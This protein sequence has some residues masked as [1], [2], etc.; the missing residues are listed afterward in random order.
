M[1][2]FFCCVL[3]ASPLPLSAVYSLG[4][5]LGVVAAVP[6]VDGKY[7]LTL[8]EKL[9]V[10]VWEV[11]SS[12]SI[13]TRQIT[14]LPR[15]ISF[16]PSRH[17]AIIADGSGFIEWDWT[18]KPATIM[19]V[20]SADANSKESIQNA[21]N[22]LFL[23]VSP[24]G[25]MLAIVDTLSNVKIQAIPSGKPKTVGSA[26]YAGSRIQRVN[27]VPGGTLLCAVDI[28]KI[29]IID[30]K[31]EK[32]I[33]SL[34]GHKEAISSMHVTFDGKRLAT[35]SVDGTVVIWDVEKRNAAHVLQLEKGDD[36][37][38]T[39]RFS[40]NGTLLACEQNSV[41]SVFRT[42]DLKLVS[43][44]NGPKSGASQIIISTDNRT[45]VSFGEG[46]RPRYW[47]LEL[48]KEKVNK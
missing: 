2:L 23:D 27:F 32:V 38:I 37:P 24:D 30:L 33:A 9:R 5:D 47:D 15:G 13:A 40:P 35:G 6:S 8:S 4:D 36:L 10:S 29:N 48:G 14:G 18:K 26:R 12:R 19:R 3:A 16:H 11:A 28:D 22:T 45:L 41:I 44:W 42:T 34:T 25:K 31:D 17:T 20:F 1:H 43:R 7:I 46:L 21:N 39:L